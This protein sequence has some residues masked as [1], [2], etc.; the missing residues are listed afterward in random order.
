MENDTLSWDIDC[1]V[2]IDDI[3]RVRARGLT[4]QSIDRLCFCFDGT[5]A[6]LWCGT[7]EKHVA[8]ADLPRFFCATGATY[9]T[10]LDGVVMDYFL[11]AYEDNDDGD[12]LSVLRF[13]YSRAGRTA[14]QYE[15]LPRK[16]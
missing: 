9:E 3:L 2:D 5:G 8:T 16:K 7:K 6:K 10:Q 4:G 1:S 13:F 15:T 11:S 12:S 14:L